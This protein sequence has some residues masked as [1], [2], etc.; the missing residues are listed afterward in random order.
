MQ[1]N[2]LTDDIGY[3]VL[4]TKVEL[5]TFGHRLL[6]CMTIDILP[7]IRSD[8]RKCVWRDA[9]Y[10]SILLMQFMLVVNQV[11]RPNFNICG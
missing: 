10:I 9:H 11:A 4:S 5:W 7:R 2:E 1:V 3:V 6:V 8:N